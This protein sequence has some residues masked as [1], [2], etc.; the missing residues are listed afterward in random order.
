M[1]SEFVG[2]IVPTSDEKKAPP[3]MERLQK[4]HSILFSLFLDFWPYLGNE[5]RYWR[6]AGAKTTIS[7]M[8]HYANNCACL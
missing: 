8:R 1:I 4:E 7:G 6:S 2:V 3:D 5:K